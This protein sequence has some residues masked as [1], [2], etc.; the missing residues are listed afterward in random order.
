[1]EELVI[2]MKVIAYGMAHHMAEALLQLQVFLAA[3]VAKLS[4]EGCSAIQTVIFFAVMFFHI[5]LSSGGLM[6]QTCSIACC[7]AALCLYL[8]TKGNI[9][10]ITSA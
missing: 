4:F 6:Y 5:R 10:A 3:I 7:N 8:N 9:Q 1:M 2:E